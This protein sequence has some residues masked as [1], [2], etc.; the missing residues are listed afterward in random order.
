MGNTITYRSKNLGTTVQLKNRKSPHPSIPQQT[1]RAKFALAMQ[2]WQALPAPTRAKWEAAGL[3]FSKQPHMLF[4]REYL[5][6][7]TLPW[8]LPL[9]PSITGH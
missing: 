2:A 5:I 4:T 1:V 9:I 7:R 3:A 6:Q 8:K